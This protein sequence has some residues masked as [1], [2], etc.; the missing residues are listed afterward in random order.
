LT[1]Y[2]DS[3]TT[4][5]GIIPFGQSARFVCDGTT[6]FMFGS[7]PLFGDQYAVGSTLTLVRQQHQGRIGRL[8]TATGSVVTLP[9]AL[10]S[11]ARF[12]FIVGVLAT[13]NSHIIK[14]ANASDAMQGIIVSMDDTS[15][16]AVAFAAVA[17]TSDTITLNRSTTGSV[18]IGEHIEVIDV[19]VNR[20]QVRGVISNTGTPATPFSAT[21]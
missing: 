18:T 10:G 7:A 5:I 1:V 2:E 8:D 16:N 17:G 19:A 6:W 3:S 21:V 4:V 15:D 20:F 13:S 12:L 11:G 9:A 14:V